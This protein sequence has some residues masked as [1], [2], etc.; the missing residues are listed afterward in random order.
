LND[1]NAITS[2]SFWSVQ[3]ARGTTS[4]F[5]ATANPGRPAKAISSSKDSSPV[6]LVTTRSVSFT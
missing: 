2:C 5:T 6:P 4:A 3:H 1:E